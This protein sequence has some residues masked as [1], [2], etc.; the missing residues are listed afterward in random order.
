MVAHAPGQK[1]AF[2]PDS[3][4]PRRVDT[5]PLTTDAPLTV[6]GTWQGIG[7][8]HRGDL[9]LAPPGWFGPGLLTRPCSAT[10]ISDR[11]R[12][13]WRPTVVERRGLETRAERVG[14]TAGFGDPRRTSRW[15][16]GVWRPAPNETNSQR[17]QSGSGGGQD[18]LCSMPPL[19]CR[20]CMICDHLTCHGNILAD[21][22]LPV[23]AFWDRARRFS[24]SVPFPR[25]S[26][27]G[28]RGHH[29]R[30]GQFR[31]ARA[32]FDRDSLL[33]P[34]PRPDQP[35]AQRPGDLERG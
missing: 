23:A 1:G 31:D 10:A 22:V 33:L 35:D 2:V 34:D 8:S 17:K 4:E 15:N 32:A 21:D 14:R 16:G 6:W 27:I 9:G 26:L 28:V 18:Q 24:R 7:L 25:T 29:I 20:R 13:T 12:A 5:K 11:R 30:A 3:S 19:P